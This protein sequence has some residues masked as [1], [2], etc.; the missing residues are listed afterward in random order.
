MLNNNYQLRWASI[1]ADI[2]VA[3]KLCFPRQYI[4]TLLTAD[5]SN[6]TVHIFADASP[7]AYRVV[8]YIQCDNQP[9]LVISKSRV[10]LIKQHSLPGLELMA[11]VVGARLG[12]FVADSFNHR[13]NN[14]YWSDS[15]IVLYWLKSK[16]KL[17]SF[18][19]HQVTEIQTTSSS[20]QYCP[21]AC[22]PVDLLTRGLTA[23]QLVDSTLWRH[24]PS[25]LSSP[26]EWSTWTPT[27][28]LLLEAAS[29]EDS[30]STM[31]DHNTSTLP[32]TNGL[33]MLIDPAA[34]SSYNKLLGITA[35]VLRFVH[36]IT[37]K[38]FKLTGPLSSSELS[39]ANIRW[40]GNVQLMC[41]PEEVA[42]LQ[43]PNH[44]T[45]LPLVR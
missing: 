41:F 35:Y 36:N 33:H 34:Y 6:T 32:P 42:S 44:S 37:Q 18:I 22:N 45:R 40:I 39:I 30:S 13:I 27:E 17:P 15:Q 3:S 25:W 8:V 14:Y 23:Q 29:V 20:W 16:K 10:A 7:K 31:N 28:A 21:T 19:A 12:S 2:S 26:N 4:P 11:A 24:G 38:Q 9:S 43:A 1:I 5:H